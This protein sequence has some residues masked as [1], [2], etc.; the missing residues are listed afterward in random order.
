MVG[1]SSCFS[2]AQTNIKYLEILENELQPMKYFPAKVAWIFYIDASNF[3]SKPRNNFFDYYKSP[4]RGLPKRWL[5]SIFPTL[6]PTDL[7]TTVKTDSLFFFPCFTYGALGNDRFSPAGL[8]IFS[9]ISSTFLLCGLDTFTLSSPRRNK[10]KLIEQIL[11]KRLWISN[12]IT[13]SSISFF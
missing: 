4:R 7:E 12:Q 5:C 1:W 2:F 11:I 10:N 13:H 9:K 3:L 8:S 6:T